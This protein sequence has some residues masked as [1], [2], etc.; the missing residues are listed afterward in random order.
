MDESQQGSTESSTSPGILSGIRI[1]DFTSMMAGPYCTRQ[2]ADLGAEIIKCEPLGGDY[3]RNPAPLREGKSTYFGHLNCGKKSLC[4]DLKHAT[5]I[6]LVKELVAVSDVVVEN[7]RPGVMK[8]LGLGY[9]TLAEV[10]PD[11][12]YCA[13]SGYGQSGPDADRPAYAPIIHAASGYDLANLEYQ[14]GLERPLRTGLYVADYFSGMTAAWGIQSALLHR[15]RTG[16]GQMVDVALIDTM[17]S[18]LVFEMQAAQFPVSEPR[19]FYSPLR[20]IDG[21]IVIMP[22]TQ[23]NFEGLAEATGHRQWR[24][25]T[26]FAEFSTRQKNWAELMAELEAWTR[27]HTSAQCEQMI[28]DACPCSSYRS[29]AEAMHS[30]QSQHR[31]VLAEVDDGAGPFQVSNCPV[32]FSESEA[33]AKP[34]VANLGEHTQ[35]VLCDLLGYSPERVAELARQGAL[36][37]ADSG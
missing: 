8:R 35:D 20:T 31:G 1:L 14:S 12:I 22:I 32:L 23:G 15:E 27:E 28:G 21:Y 2:L 13:I 25:D 5:S 18:M 17:L 9:E 6:E 24:E 33:Q 19:M 30:A 36:I 11:I 3:V 10:K 37:T 4:L 29:V 16:E 34:W 7:F 26:R